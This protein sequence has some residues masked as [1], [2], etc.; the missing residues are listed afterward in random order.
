MVDPNSRSDPK[1][2][3]LMKVRRNQERLQVP[4]RPTRCPYAT[5][6]VQAP[7]KPLREGRKSWRPL[8]QA[9][10]GLVDGYRKC[11]QLCKRGT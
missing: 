9:V 3:E 11:N 8:P 2:Q 1:L 7:H 10:G 4:H 5:C 6:S